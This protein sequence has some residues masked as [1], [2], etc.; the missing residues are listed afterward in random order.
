MVLKMADL[1][2][3]WKSL[4]SLWKAF[5]MLENA[6]LVAL[7]PACVDFGWIL[8]GPKL[9]VF[10]QKPWAIAHGF[11]NGGFGSELEIAPNSLKRF[12]YA[13]KCVS[14][15]FRDCLCRV[16]VNSQGSQIGRFW[17][18]TLGCSPWFWKWRIWVRAGNRSKL[19]ET[20]PMCLEIDFQLHSASFMKISCEFRMAR[21]R[22]ILSKKPVL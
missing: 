11:E 7:G 20:P 8:K 19:P 16:W 10:E 3:G 9:A 13:R 1:G 6:F 22:P 4:Q 14:S 21:N 15:C 17:A 2:Q 5:Y 18:K 12:L